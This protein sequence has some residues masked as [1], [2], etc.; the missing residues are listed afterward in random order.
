[1]PGAAG[2]RL[3]VALAEH[4]FRPVPLYNAIPGPFSV[5]NLEPILGALVAGAPRL[6]DLPDEAPPAFLLDARRSG[7]GQAVEPGCF[8]NRSFCSPADFPSADVFL[9]AGLRRAVLVQPVGSTPA[10]DLAPALLAWQAKGIEILLFQADA[11]APP[12]AGKITPPSV[13]TR[14]GAY[15]ERLAYKRADAGAFG[16]HIPVVVTTGGSGG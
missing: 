2:T 11:P 4:G 8:D 14:A 12:E 16:R 9:Q 6:A 15:L 5:V 13:L 10:P 1:M 7:R 3:G